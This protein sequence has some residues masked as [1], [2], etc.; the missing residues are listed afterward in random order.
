MPFSL[1][2]RTSLLN[3]PVLGFRFAVVFL[4][5]LN[6]S[7]KSALGLATTLDFCFQKVSGLRTEVKTTSLP[8]GGQN[9]YVHKLPDR[10]EQGNLTLERGFAVGSP[11]NAEVN[12]SLTLLQFQPRSVLI[13][14]LS[15]AGTPLAGWMFMRAYPIQ[16]STADLDATQTNVLIDTLELAYSRMQVMRI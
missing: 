16:W 1:P 6:T 10:I 5:H 14:L 9:H 8:E 11:L 3:D 15:E 7:A 12:A 13:S 4:P 2:P